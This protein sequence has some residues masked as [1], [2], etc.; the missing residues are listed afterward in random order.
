MVGEFS[1]A[2]FG[3]TAWLR[4]L[5]HNAEGSKTKAKADGVLVISR[6][7]PR[8]AM[9]DRPGQRFLESAQAL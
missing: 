7:L 9:C 2:E 3:P 5:R 4:A 1:L 8:V 6:S